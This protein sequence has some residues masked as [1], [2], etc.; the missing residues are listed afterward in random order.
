[1]DSYQKNKIETD[2]CISRGICSISPALSFLQ[3]VIQ[4]YLKELAF[5]LLKLKEFGITNEKIKENVIDVISG[6]I[7]SVEYSEEQFSKM[8]S[9]LYEDLSQAK[10]LYFSLC[11][12]NNIK[13]E[14][15]KSNIKSP[16]KTNYS[17]AIRLGQKIV[18]KKN[19][20]YN[21][22]QKQLFEL[23]FIVIKSI[24]IHL[25]ELKEFDVEEDGAY[26]S[27]LQLLD[28]MNAE[29]ISLESLQETI[30]KVV[31]LDRNTL[32]KLQDTREERYGAVVPTEVSLSTRPN[33]AILVSGSNIRELELLLKATENKGIDVYT[34]GHLL[35][36]HAF[37]K[38]KAY[39][40]LV[41]HFGKGGDAHMID[42][43]A[44]PG[45]VFMTRHSLQRVENLFRSSVYTT[46][47]IAPKGV[48]TIKENNYKPL[49]D[50]ALWAKGF[51][52]LH[53][54]EPIKITIEEKKILQ[55]ITEVADKI[56]SGEIKH[57]FVIGR[58]NHTQTQ[59]EYFEALLNLI[60]NDSFVLSFSYTNNASNVLCVESDY[61]FHIIYQSLKIITRKVEMEKLDLIALF[62]RCDAHTIPNLLNLKYMG[63][64]KLY[65]ADCSPTL[66]NPSIVEA[67][68]DMF[69]IKNYT[70]PKMDL[71]DMLADK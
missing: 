34:H 28:S 13:P 41:G 47:I 1:M 36:A 3:A 67:V 10:K 21:A 9:T 17:E 71:Q 57:F 4:S 11:E 63:V 27:L 49:V 6:L 54:R 64:K 58:P 53:E 55:K 66:I 26:E 38:L 12:K 44:F 29:E 52:S 23:I 32:Q 45:V 31:E 35:M 61:A 30:K 8:S 39:P 16:T 56:E 24:C 37:P 62:T 46:D 43:A 51:T 25:V 20:K 19:E 68:R 60:G 59:K 70:N 18:A 50:A 22:E 48:I 69:G 2:E 42:F 7:V 40:H 5:Y 14:F 33:K 15:L 65:F